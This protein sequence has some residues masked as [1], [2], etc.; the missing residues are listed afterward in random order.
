LYE[1]IQFILTGTG[2][3][4]S[5]WNF[6]ENREHSTASFPLERKRERNREREREKASDASLSRETKKRRKRENDIGMHAGSPD[7]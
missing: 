1:C 4:Y 3:Y 2:K 5:V 6:R 7:I